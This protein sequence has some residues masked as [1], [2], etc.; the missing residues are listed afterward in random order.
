MSNRERWLK[1]TLR[2]IGLL[3]FVAISAVFAP[4]EWIA[5]SHQWLGLGEFPSQPIVGYLARCTSVWYASY[6][7]LLWF[8]SFDTQK[9]SFL[10]TCL[11]CTLFLQGL[12]IVGIDTTEQMPGWWIAIEGPCCSGLGAILLLLNRKSYGSMDS[13]L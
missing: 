2:V 10:I 13:P 4:R 3:D 5:N 6:G 12:I 11:G 7:L 9:Y 8:I 1:W